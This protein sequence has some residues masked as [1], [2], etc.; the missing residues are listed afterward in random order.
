MGPQCG[1]GWSRGSKEFHTRPNKKHVHGLWSLHEYKSDRNVPFRFVTCWITRLALGTR[2][3]PCLLGQGASVDLLAIIYTTVFVLLP[4]VLC[5]ERPPSR[6]LFWL[7]AAG[8]AQFWIIKIHDGITQDQEETG[9]HTRSQMAETKNVVTPGLV[10]RGAGD[11]GGGE[12][13][14]VSE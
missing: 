9:K 2:H 13:W 11:R 6:Q 7:D 3:V 8:K 12:H 4:A 1:R 10:R 5:G 14:C